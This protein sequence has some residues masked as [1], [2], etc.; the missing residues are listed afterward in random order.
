MDE[1]GIRV[2]G[3]KDKMMNILYCK[4]DRDKKIFHQIYK[5]CGW[6]GTIE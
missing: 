3:G 1:V 5:S 6:V 2:L 4:K